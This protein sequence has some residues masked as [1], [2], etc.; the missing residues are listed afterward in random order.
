MKEAFPHTTLDNDAL[1][2]VSKESPT[3]RPRPS[4][5]GEERTGEEGAGGGAPAAAPSGAG[6]S[7]FWAVAP[8]RA[9]LLGGARL[10]SDLWVNKGLSGA[11]YLP[12]DN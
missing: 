10:T 6:E 9:H 7:T 8:T 11:V 2:Y 12:T 5:E 1:P 4:E 3:V